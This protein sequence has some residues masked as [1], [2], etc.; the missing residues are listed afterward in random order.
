M[1]QAYWNKA[2]IKYP[3]KAEMLLIEC[4]V[5]NFALLDSA[6]WRQRLCLCYICNAE[7]S[8]WYMEMLGKYLLIE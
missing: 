8:A 1:F 3:Q 4:H 5:V 2:G 6:L 7:P